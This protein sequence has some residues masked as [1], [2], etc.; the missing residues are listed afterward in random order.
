MP[1]M[2]R[3]GFVTVVGEGTVASGAAVGA[4]VVGW[5]NALRVTTRGRGRWTRY[6]TVAVLGA[7]RQ[8]LVASGGAVHHHIAAGQV[9]GGNHTRFETVSVDVEVHNGS[10]QAVM[11]SPGQFRL[12]AG[13]ATGHHT[14]RPISGS[15]TPNL[16]QRPRTPS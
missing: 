13:S 15:S 6:G 8:D 12:R 5:G 10:D 7:S 9:S 16:T 2:S 14:A 4:L 1:E 11:V 3:R